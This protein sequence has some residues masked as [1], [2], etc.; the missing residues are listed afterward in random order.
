[1]GS[2]SANSGQSEPLPS[3]CSKNIGPVAGNSE[4]S[5]CLG[6]PLSRQT[7]RPK[8]KL[9]PI[10]QINQKEIVAVPPLLFV[11]LQV[12]MLF[13]SGCFYREIPGCLPGFAGRFQLVKN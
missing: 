4:A 6:G 8:D 12:I 5:C 1:M 10:P 9:Q 2:S 7:P 3:F 13:F 11:L